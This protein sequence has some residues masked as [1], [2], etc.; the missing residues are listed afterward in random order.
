MLVKGYTYVPVLDGKFYAVQIDATS[1]RGVLKERISKLHSEEE[2]KDLV[3]VPAIYNDIAIVKVLNQTGALSSDI[4]FRG[5]LDDK[6][7]LYSQTG[8]QLTD[9][10]P[11]KFAWYARALGSNFSFLALGPSDGGGHDLLLINEWPDQCQILY[12][13][14]DKAWYEEVKSGDKTCYY[15]K[16]QPQGSTGYVYYDVLGNPHMTTDLYQLSTYYDKLSNK[17][18]REYNSVPESQRAESSSVMVKLFQAGSLGNKSAIYAIADTYYKMKIYDR[19]LEWAWGPGI[20][21][22]SGDAAFLAGQC[23]RLGLGTPIQIGTAK[24]FY[25]KA[26]EFGYSDAAIGLEA[27][28]RIEKPI[29]L[30]TGKQPTIDELETPFEQIEK[31]AKEGYPEAIYIYCHRSTFHGFGIGL[32]DEDMRKFINDATAVDILPLLHAVAPNDANSQFI[33]ACVYAGQEAVG[34]PRNYM[35]SFRD[36]DKAKYWLN[37]FLA[38][39]KR[40]D[41]HCW[42]YSQEDVNTIIANIKNLK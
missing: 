2:I 30:K 18:V 27:I 20:N 36:P 13:P 26:V 6:N 37:K 41:A 25:N 10:V 39:P 29:A 5:I 19:M 7:T 4:A 9:P 17:L 31:Y 32:H 21:A 1:K 3:I 14:F 23:Y 24:Y 42:G 16:A 33:L 35:Y 11:S 28:N 38:N 22:K 40:K 15:I 12:G 8:R 34:G